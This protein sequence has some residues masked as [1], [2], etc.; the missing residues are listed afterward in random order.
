MKNPPEFLTLFEKQAK[1]LAVGEPLFSRGTYQFEVKELKK[2][3]SFFPF[4]QVSDE[5]V[6]GDAFC[7][8]TMSE[9]GKG[10]EH[11]AAAYLRIYNG[12]SEPLHVRFKGSLWNRLCQMAGKRH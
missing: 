3:V 4:L 5:G 12:K 11:L 10:C 2:R 8:C 7:T 1:L 9:E 6:V